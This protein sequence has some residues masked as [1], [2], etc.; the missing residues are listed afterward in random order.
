MDVGLAHHLPGHG[1]A[2]AAISRCTSRSCASA[3]WR[4]R[5][6]TSRSGASS[7]TSPTT[8][9]AP[10]SCR[11][12]PTSPARARRSLLGSMVVVL[13]WHQPDARRRAGQHARQPVERPPHPRP[14][15][16]PR[17]GRVRGLRRRHEHQPRVL[18][19]GGADDPAGARA[20]LLRVRRHVRQAGA[21]R[22]PPAPAHDVPRPHL[23]RGGVAR[24]V[25]HHGRA[26]RRALHH[27]AE[28]VGH[29]RAGAR[30]PTA[31]S[32]AR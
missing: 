16:R 25:A 24:V 9:C 2:A 18:R 22:H 3:A 12:S 11:C 30:R 10:T 17:P 26:R 4:S 28:A 6:A 5:S 1:Q 29:G 7:T 8:R 32:I 21:A 19:R 15:A 20:R 27:P 14:R 13:P 23:R 31:T